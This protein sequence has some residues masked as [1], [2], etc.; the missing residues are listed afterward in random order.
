MAGV[1][2]AGVP[3]TEDGERGT[4]VPK[5]NADTV[6][7]PVIPSPAS[8]GNSDIQ[9]PLRLTGETDVRVN[10]SLLGLI[11]PPM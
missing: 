2:I 10:V 3:M 9:K 4:P 6:V 7:V 1:R 8:D 11:P 5:Q